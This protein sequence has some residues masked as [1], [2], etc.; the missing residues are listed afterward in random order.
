MLDGPGGFHASPSVHRSG[1]RTRA[2]GP[3]LGKGR[4]L[5]TARLA[6]GT[7]AI[8]RH[9]DGGGLYLQVRERGAGIERLWVFRYRRGARGAEREALISLGR[10]ADVGLAGARELAAK[11][12][13]A[14]AA[15]LDPR[16]VRSLERGRRTFGEVADAYVDGLAHTLRNAKHVAQWRSTLGDGPCRRLRRLPVDQVATED[17]LATLK[18]IWRTTPETAQR[19]RGRIERVLDAAAVAGERQGDN[20]ARWRGHL[21]LLLAARATL[22]RTHHAALPWADLPAFMVELRGLESVSA[23]ALEWTILNAARTSD[24]T[25]LV[26]AEL[27]EDRRVWVVPAVRMKA[28]REHRVPLTDRALEV[29]AEVRR[30]GA[31]YV[32]PSRQGRALSNMAMLECLRGLR[33]GLTV[34]G[35]RST[36]RDWV[37]DG[38]T[39][40]VEL[41]EQQ[42]AHVIG[43]KTEAAY[44][45]GDA[46]ERRRKLMAAWDRYCCAR[47]HD[48]VRQL[49]RPPARKP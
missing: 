17:V 49:H 24:T 21:Q 5:L 47:Q 12:R 10:A 31:P 36:F 9:A 34:H 30:L 48:N 8:G 28:K 20:P 16:K 35:F 22:G 43:D 32:F 25:G 37:G 42:L 15:G 3:D 18:P 44:R 38:T 11:C 7:R 13:A 2:R 40:A 29:L 33:P 4:H 27:D 14:L 26:W 6:A 45:R 41:A 19:L 23:R 46:L 1:H 39:F